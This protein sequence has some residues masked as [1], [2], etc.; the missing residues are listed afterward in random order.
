MRIDVAHDTVGFILIIMGLAGIKSR[1]SMFKKAF[2]L[3]IAGCAASILGQFINCVSW[4]GGEA[5]MYSISIGLTVIF[6]IYFSYYFNEALV[7][8]SKVQSKEAVTR[9]YRI[10]WMALAIVTFGHFI[11][12]KSEITGFAIL[13][14]ALVGVCVLYYCITVFTTVGQ[15]CEG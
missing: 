8:E 5:T 3:S 13:A 10:S 11:I 14:Q 6:A 12:F 9:S 4:T 2:I 1:N 7:L 15:L